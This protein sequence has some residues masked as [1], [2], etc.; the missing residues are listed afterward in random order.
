MKKNEILELLAASGLEAY[1]ERFDSL[2]F[3]TYEIQLNPKEDA[4]IPT[5]ASKIGGEPD[6]HADVEWPQWESHN[7]SF[8]AQINLADLSDNTLLPSEG[9]LSFF[10]TVEGLEN[11]D[12]YEA[13]DTCRVIYTPAER[14]SQLDRRSLPELAEEAVFRPNVAA[15][16][17][18]LCVPASESAYLESMDLG[19]NGNREHFDLYWKVFLEAY[20][21]RTQPSDTIHRLLGHPDQI[22][23]DMQVACEV[24]TTDLTY[25]MLQDAEV[26]ART[27]KSAL[28]W[29]L[30]LQID[31]D[32]DN[33]GIMFGDVG[34]IYFWIR[35]DDLAA[36][37]FD[38]VVCEMQCS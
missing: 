29:R 28:Q 5:G 37:R 27:V 8:V 9:V 7:M 36:Q 30:L 26:N 23:G 35:E 31:S 2:I 12:F 3:P 34:R 13:P 10:Y 18:A 6:L 20:R 38:R 22:Q 32:E 21:E 16:T 11:P 4:D 24:M 17:P 33:T 1:T 25:D 14:L 19:W 15:F